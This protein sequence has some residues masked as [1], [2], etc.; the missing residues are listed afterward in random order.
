MIS[1]DLGEADIKGGIAAGVGGSVSRADKSVTFSET[2]RIDGIIGKELDPVRG[3]GGAVKLSRNCCHPAAAR[4]RLND[5]IILQ[6]V[7]AGVAVT[8][9]VRGWR[10][11][12][13][14][15]SS[16]EGYAEADVRKNRV[17][18]D[19]PLGVA[20]GDDHTV[21]TVKGDDV[22]RA[23]RSAPDHAA[24]A[25]TA[26]IDDINASISIRNRNGAGDISSNQVALDYRPG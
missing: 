17:T 21:S 11:A 19:W 3:I 26:S 25:G 13:I 9:V 8:G 18:K 24:I 12:Q 10:R 7:R 1:A 16:T 20:A 5:R 15:G 23:E 2:G 22:S 14:I 4:N 6:I